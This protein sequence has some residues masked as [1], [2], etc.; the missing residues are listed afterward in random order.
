MKVCF[1]GLLLIALSPVRQA[2]GAPSRTVGNR[3][4]QV[5]PRVQHGVASW[6]GDREQGRLMASGEPFDANALIAATHRSLPLGAEVR[7]TNLRNG[8]STTVRV[9]DRLPASSSR[10]IDLSRHAAALLG[11]VHR[12]LAPVKLE[13]LSLPQSRT[14]PVAEPA[15]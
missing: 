7:V 10:L 14:R 5:T 6:Y 8:Q 13:V 1:V 4:A 11:F 12:G 15:R 9:E 2:L 3:A